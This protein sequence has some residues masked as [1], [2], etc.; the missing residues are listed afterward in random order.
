M[1]GLIHR[2]IFNQ[3]LFERVCDLRDGHVPSDAQCREDLLSLE[4]K[5]FDIRNLECWCESPIE[6]I[7]GAALCWATDG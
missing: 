7:F 6:L 3:K 5:T 2:Y 4:A 1:D